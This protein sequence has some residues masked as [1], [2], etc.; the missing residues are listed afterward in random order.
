MPRSGDTPQQDTAVDTV[1]DGETTQGDALVRELQKRCMA[2]EKA[3]MADRK[4]LQE[5]EKQCREREKVIANLRLALQSVQG[6]GDSAT[7]VGTR[8]DVKYQNR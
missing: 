7:A 4:E 1:E 8:T 5:K 2:E 6:W 3:L